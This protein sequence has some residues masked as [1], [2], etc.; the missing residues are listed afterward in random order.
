VTH[1]PLQPDSSSL[2]EFCDAYSAPARLIKCTRSKHY[3]HLT[4]PTR[5][6]VKTPKFPRKFY[7]PLTM[8]KWTKRLWGFEMHADIFLCS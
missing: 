7:Y 2:K 3:K 4:Q 1:I 6:K 5:M 8:F